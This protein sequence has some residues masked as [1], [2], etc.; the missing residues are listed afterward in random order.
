MICI[1]N[2]LIP[3]IFAFIGIIVGAFGAIFG[4]IIS[5][6]LKVDEKINKMIKCS[7]VLKDHIL[8]I[9]RKIE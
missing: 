6:K 2:P 3:A 9:A 5:H 4:G 1:N 8:K 7:N